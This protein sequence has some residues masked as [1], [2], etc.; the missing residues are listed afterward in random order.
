MEE[1][2]DG[3]KTKIYAM[4]EETLLFQLAIFA[5]DHQDKRFEETPSL[6]LGQRFAVDQEVLY[7][8]RD[9]KIKGVTILQFGSR[10]TVLSTDPNGHINISIEL[11]PVQPEFGHQIAAKFQET[12][13]PL[14]QISRN[15][16]IS[17]LGT[18]FP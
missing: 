2:M 4:A 8:G 14:H 15:L 10:G 5:V 3:S 12:Y 17:S 16:G 7:V 13:Y 18:N 1:K 9:A 6:P 11:G